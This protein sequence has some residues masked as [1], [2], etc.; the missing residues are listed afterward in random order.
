M[1][2]LAFLWHMHQPDYRH[3]VSGHFTRPW[4][5][6]HAIKD[7]ADMASHLERHP[8]VRCT[9]NFVPAL[10]DQIEDYCEQLASRQWRD[11][12]LRMLDAAQPDTLAEDDRRWLAEVAFQCHA[13]TMLEPFAPFRKL[14]DLMRCLQAHGGDGLNY[15]SGAYYAD[16][17]TW[18][19]LAWSGEALRREGGLIPAL[20]AKGSDFALAERRALLAELG[21]VMQALLP[22]YR[23]L[24][25]RGQIELSC[26][27]EQHP[28][29][30]LLLDFQVAREAW[31]AC[32]LP[33]APDYPGGSA[34]VQAQ[35]AAAQESHRRRF[36]QPAAGLWPPEGAL[37]P[38][39]VRQIAAAG[40]QWTASGQGV[41]AHSAGQQASTGLPWQAPEGLGDELTVFFRN[42]RLSDLI[43][44]EYAK[45][46]GQEAA[47]HFLTELHTLRRPGGQEFIPVFLDGEN[48]WAYYSYNAW[49][50]FTELYQALERSEDI[51]TVTLSAACAAHRERRVRL[52]QLVSGSWV[53]G[54]LSTWIGSPDKNRAWELLCELK[55]SVDRVLDSGRVA[56][57]RRAAVLHRLA[58]CETSDWFWWLGDYNPPMTVAYFDALY[59]DNLKAV[60]VLLDLPVPAGLGHPIS[61]GGGAPETAGTMR[62][63]Q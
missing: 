27:P 18:C 56:P 7:Y 46:N 36:G 9:V 58:I 31:P 4:V 2:D 29:A 30:P 54:T 38:A 22:R 28:L 49:H 16:L 11:P 51:R 62:R 3:P 63:A 53:H 47:R 25:E 17:A 26:S 19:V 12:L 35:L 40:F 45:W 33:A 59:R 5:L 48:A 61:Q 37:S 34:R 55:Q 6:L 14:H 20:M 32:E 23:A 15:L 60:Y 21:R 57:Q 41:L 24:A 43:G 44:F 8:G 1:A 10:L 13:P 42:D 39:F 52:P 50:F